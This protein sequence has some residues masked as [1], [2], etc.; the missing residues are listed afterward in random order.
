MEPLFRQ[1]C[2]D[3]VDVIAAMEDARRDYRGSLVVYSLGSAMA[4]K[5]IRLIG[6][7]MLARYC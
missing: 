2:P 5:L 1:H 6:D 7:H 4:Q 3:A